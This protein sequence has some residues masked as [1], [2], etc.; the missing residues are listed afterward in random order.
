MVDA[1]DR[2]TMDDEIPDAVDA[3]GAFD[4]EPP[5][6]L[7]EKIEPAATRTGSQ[8]TDDE[9]RYPGEDLTW[10]GPP[11]SLRRLLTLAELGEPISGL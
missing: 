2:T 10:A 11:G 5:A 8:G 6:A 1:R 4:P 3:V 7:A 9:R